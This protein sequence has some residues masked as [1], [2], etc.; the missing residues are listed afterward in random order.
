M[1]DDILKIEECHGYTKE[2]AF[3]NLQFNPV[4]ELVRGGNCTQSW[5]AEGKPTP[6]TKSFQN[7]AMRQLESKTKMKPG[8]GLYITIESGVADNRKRPYTVY[9]P[10]VE[11]ARHWSTIMYMVMEATMEVEEPEEGEEVPKVNVVDRGKVMCLCATLNDAKNKMRDL[12]AANH[13][14]YVALAVKVPDICPESAYCIYTPSINAKP[15]TYI[16]FG[17]NRRNG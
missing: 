9:T 4:S 8:Y 16:A 1:M 17:I 10:K 5:C 13:K 3:A 6:G 15:G 14:D 11:T 7:F 2:E 12:T